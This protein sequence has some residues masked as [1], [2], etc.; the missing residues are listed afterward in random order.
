MFFV[1]VST[2]G[3]FINRLFPVWADVMN[4]GPVGFQGIDLPPDAPAD[5]IVAAIRFLADCETSKGALVTTHKIAVYT[6]AR[7]LFA[8]LDAHAESL[9]EV[10]CITKTPQGL[11]G[12]AKDPITAGLALDLIAP[13]GHWA[14]HDTAKALLM[15][16][17]GACVALAANLLARAP[18]ARPAGIVMT[19]I[20]AGRL[21]LARTHLAPLDPGGIVALERIGGAEDHD[22]MIAG[23]PAGSLVVNGTG[24]GK[25]RPGSPVTDAAIFPLDG[26]AW[27]FNY[28]GSL[29][30]LEQARRHQAERRLAVADGWRYFLFGWAYVIADVF[31]LELDA[32]LMG[33][34]EDA[35]ER[36]RNGG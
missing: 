8:S 14:R 20:D 36:V 33:R 22:R 9:G 2:G 19:D 30:F 29:T 4:L 12:A 11:V 31:G 18:G 32:A 24:L 7:G 15:G 17:G 6:H 1:G 10:S 35:A 23:L 27:E 21:E 26:I 3:S 13:G 28:R 5:D 25:D 16:C 34:L